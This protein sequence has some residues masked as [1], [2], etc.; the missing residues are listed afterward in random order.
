M[1]TNNPKFLVVQNNESS[2]LSYSTEGQLGISSARATGFQSVK[3][4][5]NYVMMATVG[6]DIGDHILALS[7][8]LQ[9]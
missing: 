7:A 2:F 4:L 5:E 3:H 1:V 6:R 9:R 8:L